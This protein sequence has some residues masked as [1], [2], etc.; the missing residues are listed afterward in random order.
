MSRGFGH[1][2]ENF[3]DKLRQEESH[4]YHVGVISFNFIRS[5]TSCIGLMPVQCSM[6]M[7]H[8]WWVYARGF[9]TGDVRV[10]HIAHSTHSA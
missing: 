4:G 1:L 8:A 5:S 2:D 6:C 3:T 7:V 10:V 9:C